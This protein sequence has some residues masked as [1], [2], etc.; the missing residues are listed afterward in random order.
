[1]TVQKPSASFL[2][3]SRWMKSPR[4]IT[5]HYFVSSSEPCVLIHILFWAN[6]LSLILVHHFRFVYIMP[7]HILDLRSLYVYFNILIYTVLGQYD[8]MT[9]ETLTAF[10]GVETMEPTLVKILNFIHHPFS[11]PTFNYKT[12]DREFDTGK[13]RFSI[14]HLPKFSATWK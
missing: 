7:H 5:F 13:L 9:P 8:F 2:K 12:K 6:I 10:Q 4:F 1:M 14:E 3:V 11:T